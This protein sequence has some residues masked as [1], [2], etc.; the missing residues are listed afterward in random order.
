MKKPV[1]KRLLPAL[2]V[3]AALGFATAYFGSKAISKSRIPTLATSEV[4]ITDE[5][6]IARG[7]YV[8]HLSDCAACHT[9]PNN[10]LYSGGLAM[11][12]PIGAIYSTNITPDK[13]T[14]I[15]NYTLQDFAA[16]VQ[17]GVRKDGAALYPA[18]P[19]PSYVIIPDE[20]IAAMY[21]YFMTKVE[22]VKFENAES[23]IPP[24][25]NWRWPL[26]WWQ[27]LFSPD[28][29]FVKDESKSEEINHGAYLVEGPGHCGA[30]H[31]P[32]GIAYQEKALSMKG[33]NAFLSGAVIDG[34][35]A[36]SLR[37]EAR[38]LATWSEDEIAEFLKT[39][40]TD[41]VSAFGAMTDVIQH[42]TQFWS[43]EDLRATAKYL[44]SL[45]PA[46]GRELQLPPKEDTTTE[47]LLSGDYL[48]NRGAL[49]YM[50]N[51]VTCHRVDGKGVP[52]VIPALAE[53]TAITA[54]NADSII[55]I[56]LEGGAMPDT[57][58]DRMAFTMPGFKQLSDKDMAE[59]I[60]FIRNGWTNQAPEIDAVDVAKTRHFLTT[61]SPNIEY[62]GGK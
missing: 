55:Q 22:P 30:C 25:M 58:A 49:L 11:Q 13:E 12:T 47:M 16:A 51:C 28:R 32:R 60:N 29:Q 8:A 54:R 26:A 61:K 1:R 44:K 17:H 62:K 42:S 27:L 33:D 23:T 19:Y 24:V 41:K 10:P 14:G 34:W 50:D 59:V 45:P 9:A 48:N 2:A 38:G 43:D 52:R 15:G 46:K 40:R 57:P 53:N 31:T 21:A 39:G 56:T 36:K 37:G 4:D 35:R 3:I 20:D 5:K 7:E 6:L 18:M